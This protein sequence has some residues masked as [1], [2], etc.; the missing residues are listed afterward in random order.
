MLANEKNVKENGDLARNVA[1]VLMHVASCSAGAQACFDA[2]ATSALIALSREK[3][4]TEN[5][6][7]VSFISRALK[8]VNCVSGQKEEDAS[9]KRAEEE[10]EDQKRIIRSMDARRQAKKEYNDLNRSEKKERESNFLR[11]RQKLLLTAQELLVTSRRDSKVP[12]E[13]VALVALLPRDMKG[14]E[15]LD[16]ERLMYLAKAAKELDLE[17]PAV[18]D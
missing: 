5:R 12:N 6:V 9:K 7:A 16:Q 15:E 8:S 14:W 17:N 10:A 4:V 11:N 13:V 2:D 1:G 18:T 3:I